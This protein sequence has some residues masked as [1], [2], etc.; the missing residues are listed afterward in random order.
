[1]IRKSQLFLAIAALAGMNAAM[2]ACNTDQ[3]GGPPSSIPPGG[4]VIGT[5]LAGDPITGTGDA[6]LVNRYSGL[7][8]MRSSAAGHY[9]QDGSPGSEAGYIQR[10]YFKPELSS[11]TAVIFEARHNVGND[12]NTGNDLTLIRISYD[13][14]NQRLVFDGNTS[15]GSQATANGSVVNGRWYSV[16]TTFARGTGTNDGVISGI[17]VRGNAGGAVAPAAVTASNVTA[18]DT[19]ASQG[20]DYVALGWISG[21]TG[22]ALTVDAFESRRSTPIGRLRRGDSTGDGLCEAADITA[23]SRDA[24]GVGFNDISFLATS[25]QPDCDESGDIGAA[26]ISCIAVVALNDAFSGGT[27]RCGDPL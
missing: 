18:I 26:D 15:A 9:V 11:G 3:W 19:P 24:L 7:C 27:T 4:G 10:F 17:T 21:G 25:G 16:E 20:I 1:M 23:T 2:A 13:R 5:P 14:D 8:A 6:Q 12:A 22:T